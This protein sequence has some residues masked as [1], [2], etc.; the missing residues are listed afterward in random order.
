VEET[1]TNSIIFFLRSTPKLQPY[2]CFVT[3]IYILNAQ[4]TLLREAECW[5]IRWNRI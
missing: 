1:A 5:I 3:P 2:G 4:K